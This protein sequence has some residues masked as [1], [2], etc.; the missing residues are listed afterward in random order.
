MI[1]LTY[2]ENLLTTACQLLKGYSENKE[3]YKQLKNV[4]YFMFFSYMK[5][6]DFSLSIILSFVTNL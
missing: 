6:K 4:K 2:N 1:Y 3:G 5:V